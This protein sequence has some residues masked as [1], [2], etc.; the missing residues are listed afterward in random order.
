MVRF[1]FSLMTRLFFCGT[2]DHPVDRLVD[3]IHADL[4]FV[5]PDR[6]KRRLVEEVFQ[7]RPGKADGTLGNHFQLHILL[8]G[9]VPG[10]HLQ[11]GFAPL[12]I[13][14]VDGDLPVKA[15]GPEQRGIQDVRPV[16]GGH[17]D[18]RVVGVEAVHLHQQLVQ[19][20]LPLIVATAQA[21]APLP[22][23]G[24]DLVD[25]DDAGAILLRLLKQVAD[26]GGAHTDE[27]FHEV[28]TADAEKGHLGLPGHRPRQQSL[29]GSRGTHQEHP[30]GNPRPD[31]GEFPA[32]LEEIDDLH[33]LRLF[34]VGPGHICEGDPLFLLIVQLGPG[35]AEIHD[36]V[37]AALGLVQHPEE[38]EE[39]EHE[40]DDRRQKRE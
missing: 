23:D 33:Q 4:L 37:A 19:R 27:H 5:P 6:Q 38:E 11:D 20:L 40:G 13:G 16:G 14:A 39:Q 8:Q 28:G 3:L 18:D 15:A 2:G 1:S 10:V 31:G 24:I 22:S 9:L 36:P 35:F 34:L 25:E 29:S 32:V 21:G 17:H 26:P 30:F 12:H 7:V